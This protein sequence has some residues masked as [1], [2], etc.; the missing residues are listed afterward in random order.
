MSLVSV[1]IPA[2]NAG[3]TI[4][5]TIA[6]VRQQTFADF[7]LIVI[8]DGSIDNTLAQLEKIHDSRLKVFS[9][10]HSGLG[11]A[12]NRGI[13]HAR[14]EFISFI[15][16]DD[17]WTR[18][19]LQSQLERLTRVPE[20]GVAY[21]W[22][23]FIDEAGRFLFAKEPLYFEGNVYSELLLSCFVASG[24]NVLIRKG[25]I[26]SIGLFDEKLR[27]GEDW[28][29]WLRAAM[30]WPFVVVPKYQILYRFSPSS[31]SSQVET[32]ERESL[33]ILDN[34]LKAAPPELSRLKNQCLANLKQ[35]IAFLH[36]IRGS[37]S[38]CVTLAGQRLRQSIS[39]HPRSLLR[40]K[41]LNILITWLV[42]HFVPFGLAPYVV[43]SLLRL[44][45]RLTL[46][47]SPEL[48][49]ALVIKTSSIISRIVAAGVLDS[50]ASAE[51]VL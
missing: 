33:A 9:Y 4:L 24:S 49:A 41:T 23:M 35:Y 5:E 22:T 37:G 43:R 2:Y 45:G 48:R 26:D 38:E 1:I 6:S 16:A 34:A 42:L 21:S 17:L 11:A 14:G 39:L 7:E 46:L 20:A 3:A 8:D 32:I 50:I 18:E 36:L 31:L 28:E 13:E 47:A 27:S 10:P 44:N 40:R 30:R 51:Q 19:K 25:C 15:D 12:R 29:Y